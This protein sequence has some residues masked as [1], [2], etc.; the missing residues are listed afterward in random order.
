MAAVTSPMLTPLARPPF[1]GGDCPV[2]CVLLGVY[3][4]RTSVDREN[5]FVSVRQAVR[6]KPCRFEGNQHFQRS[7]S[8][9]PPH[10]RLPWHAGSRQRQALGRPNIPPESP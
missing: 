6:G 3:T 8:R 2:V 1:R 5:S 10:R 4:G 9:A 7:L